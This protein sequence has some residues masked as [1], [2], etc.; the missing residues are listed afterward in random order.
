[1]SAGAITD[2]DLVQAIDD[3]RYVVSRIEQLNQQITELDEVEGYRRIVKMTTDRADLLDQV[4]IRAEKL[5]VPARA[6]LLLIGTANKLR[7]ER[8]SQL[9]TLAV[10]RNH[11][12][13]VRSAAERDL[14]EA[15][16][17][18]RVAR[19]A[20]RTFG[21]RAKAG[22]DAIAYLDASRS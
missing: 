22:A 16:A 11:L 21:A 6:L 5:N 14:T 17:E 12:D 19:A 15:D 7:S 1:M 4:R 2:P 18:A 20:A 10:V 9:P 3:L 13:I 8:K